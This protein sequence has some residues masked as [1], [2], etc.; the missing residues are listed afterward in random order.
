MRV[1]EVLQHKGGEVV[2]IAANR[3]V[4]DAISKLNEHRMGALIVTGGGGEVRGIITERD[5]LR[6]CGEQCVKLNDPKLA[7][8]GCPALVADIM[9]TELVIGVPDDRLD[10]VMGVM[11]Q[12][13]IR[14]LPIMD[15]GSLVGI[16]SIGD[17]VRA[18]LQETQYENRMLKDYIHGVVTH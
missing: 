10:Y 4:H 11:T 17:V 14:H 8:T 5:I 13:R 6:M 3:T 12:N 7:G 18:H 2:T 9:T 15:A 1:R 16:V